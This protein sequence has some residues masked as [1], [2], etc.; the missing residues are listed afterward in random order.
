M[1]YLFSED[2]NKEFKVLKETARGNKVEITAGRKSYIKLYH[3][4]KE[5]QSEWFKVMD[6]VSLLNKTINEKNDYF[7][8][9]ITRL[10][11]QVYENKIVV[12]KNNESISSIKS[13]CF[14]NN[15]FRFTLKILM[16][17]FV[18]FYCKSRFMEKIVLIC[19]Q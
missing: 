1:T 14:C 5:Y 10:Y 16:F 3:M 15:S 4:F 9:V 12:L 19:M 11:D 7:D 13:Q 8:D 18:N 17:F 6:K 2:V